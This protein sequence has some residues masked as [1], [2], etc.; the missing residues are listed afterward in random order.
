MENW[1]QKSKAYKRYN[2]LLTKSLIW[3]YLK[4]QQLYN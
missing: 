1:E 3:V 2:F 4:G